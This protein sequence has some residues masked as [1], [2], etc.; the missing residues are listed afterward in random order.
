M[1]LTLTFVRSMLYVFIARQTRLSFEYLTIL[2]FI[3]RDIWR[4][5]TWH[6]LEK[7]R[8]QTVAAFLTQL[9]VCC[10]RKCKVRIVMEHFEGV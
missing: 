1:S 4:N 10:E 8:H 5:S 9:L 2:S 3:L 7:L 6:S